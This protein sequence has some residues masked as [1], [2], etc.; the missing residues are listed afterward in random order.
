M[1]A[2]E[3]RYVV[4]DHDNSLYRDCNRILDRINRTNEKIVRLHII[5]SMNSISVACI[6]MSSKLCRSQ[7][8]KME[9]MVYDRK[10]LELAKMVKLDQIAMLIPSIGKTPPD[11]TSRYERIGH[12]SSLKHPKTRQDEPPADL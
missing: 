2:L 7:L 11:A 12:E 8:R 5:G 3:I 6:A 4:G 1:Q 9:V 10:S